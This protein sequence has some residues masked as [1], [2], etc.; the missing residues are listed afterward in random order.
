MN[1]QSKERSDRPEIT[2]NIVSARNLCS[3]TWPE[4]SIHRYAELERGFG[5]NVVRVNHTWWVQI[6]PFFFRPVL[7]FQSFD[8]SMI[9]RTRKRGVLQHAVA[10]GEVYDSYLNPIIFDDVQN[11]D[12]NKL[13]KNVRGSLKKALSSDAIV[14]R[15]V[16]EQEFCKKGYAV[17][18]SFYERT[19]Y[20]FG[21]SKKKSEAEFSK[22]ARLLFQFPELV[23]L[24]VFLADELVAFE[25][26]CVVEETLIIKT[27]VTSDAALKLDASDLLLHNCRISVIGQEN[28]NQIYYG[29]LS[30]NTSLNKF[31]T[32]RGGRI[33]SLPSQTH[34]RP[35]VL[36]WLKRLRPS[37]HSRICG[38]PPSE[39]A[40]D[41][42]MAGTAHMEPAEV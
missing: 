26:T 4:M 17:Y 35:F 42:L 1:H 28:I 3:I 33:H 7:P 16:D 14:R 31:K 18:A 39:V 2:P 8:S 36:N 27:V 34:L 9:A 15:I 25:L 30:R 41:S 5:A 40:G 22:W 37:L 24:G 20:D 38:V 29:M 10:N 12:P 13:R 23:I 21:G 11:Y 6:R 19:G 32:M